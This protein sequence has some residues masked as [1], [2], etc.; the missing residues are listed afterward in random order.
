MN[1]VYNL[2]KFFAEQQ[3]EAAIPGLGVFFKVAT[4]DTGTPLPEGESVILFIEKTPRS[5]AFVNFLGYEENLTENEA[6]EVIEQW[7]STI[8]SDLKTKKTANIPELGS[9]EIK[10]D[11]VFFKP[12]ANQNTPDCTPVCT[13]NM[14]DEY[15]LEE[16]PKNKDA[17]KNI[18]PSVKP[19]VKPDIKSNENPPKKED[20]RT[21]PLVLWSIIG[22]IVIVLAG[23]AIVSYKMIPEFRFFVENQKHNLSNIFDQNQTP[24]PIVIAPT[25]PEIED[26]NFEDENFAE[27]PER[28]SEITSRP[29]VI[30]GNQRTAQPARPAQTQA[31]TSQLP[32][33]VIG[34]AFAIKANADNFLAQ[35]RRDGFNNAELI[36]CRN[37]QLH[38]VSL[39]TFRTMNEALEFKERI[40]TT[41]G[42][43]C[44]IFRR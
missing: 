15:G 16:L 34:G 27:T 43:E 8:L 3:D 36:F 25:V 4:D 5:N 24:K 37:R 31:T 30:Q 38:L 2:K 21:N 41:K 23:G 11:K 10:K 29:E 19:S 42:I 17:E 6:V 20:Q 33:A 32:F 1:I 40:R 39:G 14:P 35:M 9:F 44:W 26:E 22:A 12:A 7:V 18:T 13:P 28:P